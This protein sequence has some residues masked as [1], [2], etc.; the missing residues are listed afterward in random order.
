MLFEKQQHQQ[1]CVDNIIQAL[2]GANFDAA[3]FSALGGNLKRLQEKNS[4][5]RQ[6]DILPEK[7]QMDVLMETGTGKTFAYL[8][9][10]FELNKLYNLKKFIIVVPRTA[11][12]Q[13]VI[14]NV[15]L[16]D[17][18]FY[19]LYGKHLEYIN[20][21]QQ[22]L[23]KINTDFVDG[24]SLCALIATNSAF[25]SETNK[26]NKKQET[27]FHRH[28]TTWDGIASCNPVV[29]IDEPHLLKGDETR[30]GLRRLGKSLFI[31]FGA[32]FPS[33]EE[34][35]LSNVA[36]VLDSIS[37]FNR[38]L[39][40]R[41]GVSTIH[42]DGQ[43]DNISVANIQAK[44]QHFDLCFSRDGRPKRII[45]RKGDDI[46][47]KSGLAAHE[48]KV[49]TKISAGSVSLSSQETLNARISYYLDDREIRLMMRQAIKLHFEKE[50]DLFEQG[51]KALTL[52]FIPDVAGFRGDNP[53][54]KNIFEEEYKSMRKNFYKKS[55][56]A[57]YDA[58]L[59]KDFDRYKNL[60][61]HGG[62]FS[63]DTRGTNDEKIREGVDLILNHKEKLLSF[64]SPLRFIF[65]VWALQEGWDNPNIFTICKLAASDQE[66][67]RRQQVGRGLR[68]AVNQN[69][70]RLT[71]SYLGN[72]ENAFY[73]VNHLDVVV[74]GQEKNFIHEIQKEIDAASYDVHVGNTLSLCT[75]L[76]MGLIDPEAVAIYATL[77][78]A[79][80]VGD[81]GKI[82]KP[83]ADF[84]RRERNRFS[85]I[86]DVRFDRIC[87]IF[88]QSR[89]PIVSDNNVERSLVN[90][91]P[92]MWEK[93]SK[94]WE[95][96]NKKANIVYR[97]INEE[98]LIEEISEEFNQETYDSALRVEY[99]LLN[100]G[101]IEEKGRMEQVIEPQPDSASNKANMALD[102]AREEK[103]PIRFVCNLLAKVKW[104]SFVNDESKARENLVQSLK[105]KIHASILHAINYEF[106][107]T[108]IYPNELQNDE[109]DS[110]K[111]LPYTKLGHMLF[112][113]EAN[114]PSHFLYDKIV[115][116]SQIE[117]QSSAEASS[118]VSGSEIVVFAK[119]PRI[120]IPT[121]YKTYNPD[122][123]YL[124][125]KPDGKT[126]FLVV[127]TK[128]YDKQ[129]DI[130]AEE[131]VKINYGK[132]FFEH[133]RRQLPPDIDVAYKTRINPQSLSD[134]I[135]EVMSDRREGA[136]SD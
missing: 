68:I 124:I 112:E 132:K 10:I 109:G 117:R 30:R 60:V 104:E 133:L 25:N 131:Q 48:G 6:F 122:F 17:E 73:E 40:K 36:Y 53:R 108:N 15:K 66:T 113:P 45:V 95:T 116:D 7:R 27:M 61:V 100:K 123:A 87:S 128:G 90:I 56:N 115:Y 71:E 9:V 35:K 50:R 4:A 103:L 121:P 98:R 2:I 18:Y 13:G 69:K 82:K 85:E 114:P 77:T 1:N 11:I 102:I 21:P 59:E 119:L 33:K 67:S 120:S 32:T 106:T 14:Q 16:T 41:I 129:S 89:R 92:K 118:N 84:L 39:V 76:R 110:V 83:I 28:G 47:A 130:P 29:I 3:D 46:G 105:N 127:E 49:V 52:T 134:L 20:Y 26:I 93:F 58:Y 111:Q 37:A 31:R 79:D 55:R 23:E 107:E 19:G 88:E 78:Q 51:V 94:L 136:T 91:K 57:E 81:D 5:Y 135:E 74:S 64:E 75:L 38:N 42:K 101:K 97:D 24:D 34:H 80:I 44:R 72:D 70:R 43:D 22:G 65:S 63:G 8:N 125:S 86:D 54:I 126:L 99:H 96:I 12:K 62:Y